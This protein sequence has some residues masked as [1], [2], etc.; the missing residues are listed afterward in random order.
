MII[1]G[2][3]VFYWGGPMLERWMALLFGEESVVSLRCFNRHLLPT[4]LLY[5]FTF[6]A[7]MN[8]YGRCRVIR[9]VLSHRRVSST[10]PRL[11]YC[12]SCARPLEVIARDMEYIELIVIDVGL[13]PSRSRSLV[14]RIHMVSQISYDKWECL[15]GG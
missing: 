15:P 7:W 4:F 5:I 3:S 13:T 12:R 8:E 10:I 2:P 14:P 6:T 9:K 11:Y 1:S